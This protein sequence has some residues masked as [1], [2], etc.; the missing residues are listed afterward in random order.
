MNQECS[1]V[2]VI[3]LR[4]RFTGWTA[5]CAILSAFLL[6]ASAT[7]AAWEPPSGTD[8]SRPRI[9]FRPDER[10]AVQAK[11]DRKPLPEYAV[12]VLDAMA[13][14]TALA[15]AVALDD[16][17]IEAHRFKSRAAKNLA[18]HYAV[19]R[20]WQ[21][22]VI[23]PFTDAERAA[24]GDRVRDLLVNLFPRSR[25]AV[26]GALGGSDRDI[27]SSEELIQYATAY[28]ALKGSGYPFEPADEAEIRE[29]LIDLASELYENYL[30]PAT[31][32]FFADLH[33]NNHRSKAGAA[34]AVAALVLSDHVPAPAD[35]PR[36]VRDP[37]LWLDYGLTELDQV[38]GHVLV[39]GDGVYGEGPFYWRYS[40]QNLLPF[41]RA[42]H[43]VVGAP[44]PL[45]N[46]DMFPDLWRDP[47]FL[48]THRWVLDMSL[49]DG[50]F[51]HIDDGNV[52][53]VHYFGALPP[54]PDPGWDEAYAWRWDRS[55]ARFE[56]DGN[57]DLGADSLIT[58]DPDRA[59]SP[60]VGGATRFYPQGGS[61][62]LRSGWGEDDVVAVVQGEQGAAAQLG[63]DRDGLGVGPQSHEHMD[64][65]GF[66]FYAFGQRLA[67]DP[68]FLRFAERFKV[69][70]S[71]HHNMVLV[72]GRGTVDYLGSSLAWPVQGLEGPP[73]A[74]GMAS[75]VDTVDTGFVDA[76]RVRSRYGR[77]LVGGYEGGV[78]VDRRFLFPDHRYLVIADTLGELGREPHAF[79]W[80]LHGNGGGT[81]GGTFEQLD[82]GGRWEIGGAR[83]DG[84]VVYDAGPATVTTDT[85]SH[86]VAGKLERTHVFTSSEVTGA[87]V[88][89][90]ALVY[91]TSKDAAPATLI[92]LEVPGAAAIGLDD[93]EGD[94]A[95]VLIHRSGATAGS[96]LTAP[97]AA[98][99]GA[100]AA[101][102]GH[103]M[104]FDVRSNGA[105]RLAW[106]EG[107][108]RIEHG[109]ELLIKADVPGT[110]GVSLE[111]DRVEVFADSGEDVVDIGP[112]GFV[113]VAVDGACGFS[114][115]AGGGYAVSRVGRR[116]F[117]LRAVAGNGRPA[118]DPGPGAREVRP[119]VIELDGTGSCDPD[120]D[121]LAPSWQIVAA[122]PRS[123]WRLDDADTWRPRL[124]AD[125][126]GTYRVALQVRDT[127]GLASEPAE[128]SVWIGTGCSDGNDGDGDALIDL[129]DPGC[130]DGIGLVENP[131]CEN[132]RDDDA[133]DLID[134]PED[135]ECLAPSQLSEATSDCGLG[136][137]ISFVLLGVVAL[138]RRR[139]QQ[140]R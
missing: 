60:P 5:A 128:A 78:L 44:I 91:P 16:E 118:A 112:L 18:F 93:S 35:D 3:P 140:R 14:R 57:I 115:R 131:S 77:G 123:S 85:S 81:S 125:R 54:D 34:L 19:D 50:S 29:R 51:A 135:P 106:A 74:D 30:V 64:P 111:S 13:S 6:A 82:V 27:S 117:V 73:F 2:A 41:A 139:S 90:A 67:L 75:M 110:L 105:L 102:D 49:P 120:G 136:Y 26:G 121:D 58:Y 96:L 130:V 104:L 95:V 109:G 98:L 9:L 79:S 94:R 83:L 45:A 88:H 11:L 133:D 70:Q 32:G 99:G 137:E 84:G 56:T 46:G 114:E 62:I 86:E 4:V 138:S 129:Q 61:A 65:G 72:D 108:T 103:L 66:M 100:V 59:L 52:G 7:D 47:V 92:E 63:R 20:K 124:H 55:P 33:Q 71:R 43:G 8:M 87:R 15:D 134:F 38:I 23:I 68:G 40:S 76:V 10:A 69:N 37:A 80:L 42:W 22:G 36:G 126:L 21:G 107:A 28:D 1:I 24:V 12:V 97:S 101:S 31:A 132:G 25:L 48:R 39:T 89:G 119:R 116:S 53:R 127:G 17:G 122:P 113:P